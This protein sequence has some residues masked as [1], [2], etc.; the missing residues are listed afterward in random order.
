[1]RQLTHGSPRLKV[2]KRL[3]VAEELIGGNCFLTISVWGSGAASPRT[4]KINAGG[5]VNYHGIHEAKGQ[6]ERGT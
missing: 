3:G 1:V 4:P 2:E 6:P 5:I